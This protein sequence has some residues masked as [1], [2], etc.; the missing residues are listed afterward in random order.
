MKLHVNGPF[1]YPKQKLEEI[2]V[3]MF[4]FSVTSVKPSYIVFVALVQ[5]AN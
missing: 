4:S 1:C 2:H 5:T 3:Y